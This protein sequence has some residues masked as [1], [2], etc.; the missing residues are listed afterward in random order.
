MFIA[1]WSHWGLFCSCSVTQSCLTLCDPRLPCPSLPPGV[2]SN[3]I[4]AIESSLLSQW[5]HPT[6]SSSV[7]PF[8]SCLLSFPA[9]ESFSGS[10]PFTSG[11]Q[12]T[13]ASASASVL[14]MNIQGWFPLGQTSLISLLSK[15]FPWVL[16]K[17]RV[18]KHQF[19]STHH[20]LW[21]NSHIH[22]WLEKP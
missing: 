21:S 5:C 16:S 6:I 20:F 22:T 8:S 12:S 10:Q 9:S 15:G 2:C 3:L 7:T 18:H 14:P 11:G 1:V 17:N 19:F 13:R 4:W